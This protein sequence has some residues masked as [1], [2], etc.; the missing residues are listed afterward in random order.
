MFL[1]VF[2]KLLDLVETVLIILEGRQPLLIHIFHHVITLLFT[3]HKRSFRWF[4]FINL[5]SHVILYSYLSPKKFG[6]APCWFFMTFLYWFVGLRGRDFHFSASIPAGLLSST[7]F[8]RAKCKLF[9]NFAQF[10][11]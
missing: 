5:F 9:I 2:T 4:V 3:W 7:L 6:I 10:N 11:I 1:F 8:H